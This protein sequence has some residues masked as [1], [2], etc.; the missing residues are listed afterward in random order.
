VTN[1]QIV[2]KDK[3]VFSPQSAVTPGGR[4]PRNL[5]WGW[6]GL[7]V[8]VLA[9]AAGGG[10]W[11]TALA[12][13]NKKG[14]GKEAEARSDT[15][16]VTKVQVI[17]PQRG[18]MERITSQPGT[19]RAFEFA[20]L[21]TK[22]SGFV[23][24]LT[25]DRGSRVKKNDLLAEIYDPER[26]VAVIQ[27]RAS[28]EHANA[29]VAQ[30]EADILTAHATVLAAKA[31]QG[32]AKA[33]LDK[34]LASRDYR[35][36]EYERISELVERKSVEP[37]LKDEELDEYHSSEAAVLA[38]RAGIETAVAFLAE[39]N[40]KVE[41]AR[42]DKKSAVARVQVAEANL[43]MSKVFVQ[44]TKIKSPY[45]GVVTYRGE[46]VH[47]GSF[48]RAADQGGAN[49][50]LLTVA[51]I[52]K[53]RTIIPVPDK[54]VPYCHVGDPV[55]ITIDALPGRVFHAKVDRTSESETLDD[56][57]M[58][59]ESDLENSDG[60][61]RDGMFVRADILLEK[62]VKN[63]T[64]P[65]SCLIDRNGKG[66]GAVMVVKD[67]K[68]HRVNVKVGMD[69][70]LRAEIVNGLD[71]NDQVI[72]QPDP[73]IADGTSVQAESVDDS[74]HPNLKKTD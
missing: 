25:V 50:P 6:L 32:E 63:L 49:V 18:G 69:T 40:A 46:S 55:T 21:Y 3:P 57:L 58:R 12:E 54:D 9:L 1:D 17:K 44:Y 41:K 29:E 4:P 26:D 61:L 39:A 2:V 60:V 48:V 70:G 23:K 73:S 74:V 20:E 59:V 27:A 38:A 68:I 37:R 10:V 19:I 33:T 42:A 53:M 7:V 22:V 15:N 5:S 24:T 14:S 52:D 13:Q 51:T 45:D 62:V 65:S 56:R 35:K 34:V 47:P 67:G 11:L 30:A 31:K 66:D 72:L 36:K 28:L 64:V 71:E 16:N 8:V 43:E